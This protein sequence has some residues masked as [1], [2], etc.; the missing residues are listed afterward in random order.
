MDQRREGA[1]PQFV[2]EDAQG[3]ILGV[4]RVDDERQPSVARNG[5]VGAKQRLLHR[6]IRLVVVVVEPSLADPDHFRMHGRLEQCAFAEVGMLVGFVRVD[7]DAGPHVALALGGADYARPFAPPRRDVEETADAGG[8]RPIEHA[9]LVFG[10]AFVFKV[11][12]AV[13]EHQAASLSGI[14]RRGKRPTG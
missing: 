7:A 6:S 14:S 2:F 4:A 11:T 1:L 3:V 10:E 12:M 8:A 13:D 5:D 9:L